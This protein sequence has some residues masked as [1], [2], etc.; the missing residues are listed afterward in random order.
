MAAGLTVSCRLSFASPD[1]KPRACRIT[2][3]ILHLIGKVSTTLECFGD[4]TL[5]ID[6]AFEDYLDGI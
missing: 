3:W 6:P 4:T 2:T 1:I 5:A